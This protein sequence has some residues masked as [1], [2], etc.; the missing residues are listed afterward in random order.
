MNRSRPHDVHPGPR[1]GRVPA[2][3]CRPAEGEG[4]EADRDVD[5][6]DVPPGRREEVGGG[7]ALQPEVHDRDL[8]PHGVEDRR[9][10]ERSRGHAQERQGPDHAES[11]RSVVSVE[12]MRRGCR[13]D[14]HQRTTAKCLHRPRGHELVERL[15]HPGQE[16]AQ[17]EGDQR[18]QE[19]SADAPQVREPARERHR[20]HVDEQVDVD[21]PACVAEV[22]P[23]PQVGDDRAGSATAVII[24]S[25]PARKTPV[26]RTASRT[27]ATRRFI[28]VSV[29]QPRGGPRRGFRWRRAA[30]G[31][32]WRGRRR[33]CA[34]AGA[35]AGVSYVS[36]A[37]SMLGAG[38]GG[39]R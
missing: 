25:R 35:G 11:P 2:R 15:G 12:E 17:R 29:G 10:Q 26:P 23:A 19:E 8:G 27:S 16:R 6:E 18:P 38:G 3:R 13:G 14:R 33:P 28:D 24:S 1:S 9:P 30:V 37:Y 36:G 20:G 4:D 34:G 21:D 5:V 39:G 32:G 22:G 31:A 7:R